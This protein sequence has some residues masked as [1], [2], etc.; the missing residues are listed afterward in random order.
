MSKSSDALNRRQ[1]IKGVGLTG[2]AATIGA[3]SIAGREIP[4]VL[5]QSKKAKNLI[6]LIADG[7]GTG[8]FSLAH[9][10]SLYN[11][12]KLLNWTDLY[13]HPN[14]S[15]ALQ[16]TASASS[17]VTDSA[18]AASAWGCGQRVMNRSINTDARGRLLTPLFSYAK[19]A[20]KATGLVTTCR[21]THATP[22][23]FVANVVDRD[24]EDV[25][26]QQ[27]LERKVDVLLGGGRQHF[28][29]SVTADALESI[30][31]DLIP[32]FKAKG[33]TYVRNTSELNQKAMTSRVLGLFSESHMPYAI[34]RKHDTDLSE[35]PDLPTL[36]KAALDR[37]SVSRRGFA[38]QV[39]AGR[40]DHAG[41]VND[42]AAILHEF[43]EFD[44][45]IPIALEYLAKEPDTLII[46]TTDHGTGG[47]QLNGLGE[48][49]N[50]SGLALG[51]IN[52][53]TASF[54]ALETEFKASGRFDQE[55][56]VEAT[57]IAPTKTQ[58]E[59]IQA[60]LEDETVDYLS[61]RMTQIVS[62]AMMQTMAVGWT[63]NNHTAELVDLLALGPGSEQV[64]SFIKNNELFDIMKQSLGI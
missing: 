54:E 21:I 26:A 49:Y 14:V 45:C 59:A 9:H 61:S 23:G 5:S 25:V 31:V 52:K 62:E 22:A 2:V 58:S 12:G 56:F 57:G 36:F 29:R 64:A 47:C 53:A 27:Y 34:D 19:A 46:I 15:Q 10:W 1:F 50:D 43:L 16:D 7:M 8:T 48:A 35:V 60:A 32:K 55:R 38:L 24:M 13:R 6:F 18:A 20:G 33:Y 40:I 11:S 42:P 30:P 44:R 51:N 28:Q 37:L 39:E 63:S 17:P 3:S 4:E 41:H